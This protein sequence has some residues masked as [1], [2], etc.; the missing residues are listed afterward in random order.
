VERRSPGRQS[1]R[2]AC[3][4]ECPAEGGVPPWQSYVRMVRD[5]SI[6][7]VELYSLYPHTHS[8]SESRPLYICTAL[9]TQ[10]RSTLSLSAYILTHAATDESCTFF[11]HPIH[12]RISI[13]PT[14]SY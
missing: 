13:E 11:F 8:S 9:Y 2:A 3:P 6:V 1:E 14:H 10:R 5:P 4:A 12:L 7:S